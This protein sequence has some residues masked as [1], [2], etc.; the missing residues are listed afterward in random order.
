MPNVSG[1][2]V[3]LDATYDDSTSDPTQKI[4]Q[5]HHD[6]VHGAVKALLPRT[7]ASA[8]YAP[9]ES[10]A[11]TGTPTLNGG[12]VGAVTSVDGLSGAVDLSGRYIT[13]G[14]AVGQVSGVAAVV[15][16]NRYNPNDS[17]VKVGFLLSAGNPVASATYTTTGFIAV[18]AGQQ[19]TLSNARSYA[20]YDASKVF[21][22]Q[23][24]K[25][26]SAVITVTPAADGYLRASFLTDSF[27]ATFQ[28]EPGASATS[29]VPFLLVIPGLSAE[30]LAGVALAQATTSV[31]A[32]DRTSFVT[33]S[34]N[35]LDPATTTPDMVIS[36]AAAT[37]GQP[38]AL[39][40][41]TV[42]G[43]I[44]VAAD[45]V[46][47]YNARHL[48]WYDGAKTYISA[49]GDNAAHAPVT[50][51]AP[52]GA[53]FAR[54]DYSTALAPTI[55]VE[56]GS[57]ATA[58]EPFS[59][60][61]SGLK[62]PDPLTV[63]RGTNDLTIIC[64]LG[65]SALA[66]TF[67][68]NRSA[69]NGGF[70]FNATTLDGT[71][72]HGATGGGDDVTPIRTQMGTLGANHGLPN[73]ASFA[74]PDA[75]TAA[76]L[77]SVWTDGTREY[78]LLAVKA[79]GRLLLGGDFTNA[80]GIVRSVT[81]APSVD[82]T[83]V[84]GATKT[85]TIL[86][87][88]R[89]VD[90]MYPSVGRMSVAVFCDGQ[91]LTSAG[92]TRGATVEVRESYE[93]LDYA[94]LYTKAKANIGVSYAALDVA[95]AVRITNSF[96]FSANGRAQFSST[97]LALARTE[98]GNSGWL[99]SNGLIRTGSSTVRYLPG[100]KPIGGFDFSL[101]V[102]L[103]TYAVSLLVTTADLLSAGI[104]PVFSLDRLVTSGATVAGFAVGYLPY[105]PGVGASDARIAAASSNLWDLRSTDKSYPNAIG[106]RT[107][108]PG[109]RLTVEGFRTY[110]TT[111]QVD[112]TIAHRDALRAWTTLDTLT[113]LTVP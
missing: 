71:L 32:P 69:Y 36:F 56:K 35:L 5:Q 20:F 31:V 2:P 14:G 8:T 34:R 42:S 75:K 107:L 44:L 40:G 78:V 49:P 22:S 4:H 54:V 12:P 70:N 95:G 74:N 81:V 51:T 46:Y 10:P 104:P 88:S 106:T 64:A 86:A 112:A 61:I 89:A 82:L 99:Q 87:S 67:T 39:A 45:Q 18:T 37:R 16:K 23:P 108:E 3:D 110:L 59:V 52:A 60:N 62:T 28:V 21:L 53:S 55:Q 25:A 98:L 48:A 38:V 96:R 77:G 65:A 84:S 7:E 80:S 9:L 11:L 27:A 43:F 92:T 30:R 17:D 63:T 111:T 103:S 97:L 1:L 66:Q 100:V 6:T 94:D 19:Y 13:L 113:A 24:A 72:I 47:A 105:A 41:Y 50:A 57:A 29:Y 15:S 83:H 85:G 76:D 33:S 91:P 109:E 68:L 26:D 101:G 73:V 102:D 90:Q 79:D 93:V 58:Y